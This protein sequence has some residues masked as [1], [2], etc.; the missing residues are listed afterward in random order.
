[1]GVSPRAVEWLRSSGHDAV[2]LREEGLQRLPDEGVFAKARAENR[3][4]LTFDL[5]FGE[6]V[7][8]NAGSVVSVVV[9]RLRDTRTARVIE[10]LAD[11]LEQSS[12]ALE[13]GAIIVV[14]DDR[15]RVRRLPFGS[16]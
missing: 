11:V 5:D 7:A 14:E 1:M 6:I 8:M 12:R 10:R 9:F 3:I 16:S 15:H 4:L 13:E 2:H